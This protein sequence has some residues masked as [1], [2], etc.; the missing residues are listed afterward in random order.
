MNREARRYLGTIRHFLHAADIYDRRFHGELR[1]RVKEYCDEKG[2]TEI[3]ELREEFGDERQIF[4]DYLES[5]EIE[6]SEKRIR[7]T[8][9]VKIACAAIIVCCVV[10][11]VTFAWEM[12]R[13]EK[14]FEESLI[15]YTE[16]ELEYYDEE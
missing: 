2:K 13:A 6:K 12:K 11:N 9:W 5:M 3:R 16:I 1:E 8:H 14:A 10:M 15:N 7:W 4:L